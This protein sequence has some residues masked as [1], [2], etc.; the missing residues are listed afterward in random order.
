MVRPHVAELN[1]IGIFG[2]AGL[3]FEWDRAANRQGNACRHQNPGLLR[4]R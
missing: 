1:M 4:T 3:G 2:W